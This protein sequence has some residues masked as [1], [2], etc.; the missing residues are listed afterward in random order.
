MPRAQRQRAI[1]RVSSDVD[2]AFGNRLVCLA[3]YGS[4]ANESFIPE[5]SDL[6]FAIV[7]EAVTIED[8]QALQ[9]LLPAW[10]RL[11]VGTPLVVDL[12]FLEHARDVFPIEL[13]EIRSSHR[14]L[15][16]RDVFSPLDIAAVDLR[17]QLE[18]E[19]R[20]KLLRLR[21]Q[22][23][24]TGGKHRQ[25]EA[26][27]RDSLTSFLVLIRAVLRLHDQSVPAAQA[28]VLDHLEALT[29]ES[30]AAIRDI[31]GVKAGEP[32]AAADS[33]FR[34]YLGDVERLVR[35]IDQLTPKSAR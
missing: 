30:F 9:P 33:L 7:L 4:A 14:L 18:Q 11:G 6:N 35:A 3:L 25:V 5:R 16:G 12:D 27:M 20:A 10:H 8:L 26:L 21:V 2:R 19:A 17:R 24:E 28:A 32:V 13:E 34:R 1:E 29:G 15:A 31:V 23:A 22:Y